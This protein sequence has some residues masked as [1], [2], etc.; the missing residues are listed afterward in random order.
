MKKVIMPISGFGKSR[1]SCGHHRS[2]YNPHGNVMYKNGLF[3]PKTNMAQ[4]AKNGK[5]KKM[6]VKSDCIVQ[7]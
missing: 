5:I 6:C 7:R 2:A 1:L 3:T 4:W